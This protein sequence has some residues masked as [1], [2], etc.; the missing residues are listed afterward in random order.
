MFHIL[1]NKQVRCSKIKYC[2]LENELVGYCQA[3]SKNYDIESLKEIGKIK[4][5]E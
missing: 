5:Q 2:T 1:K 3:H 4:T